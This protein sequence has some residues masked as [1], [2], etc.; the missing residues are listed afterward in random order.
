MRR[1]VH[2]RKTVAMAGERAAHRAILAAAG[3]GYNPPLDPDA[4]HG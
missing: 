2:G 4:S 3:Q 1:A